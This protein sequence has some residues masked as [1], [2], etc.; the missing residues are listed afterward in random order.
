MCFQAK[1]ILVVIDGIFLF[2]QVQKNV[3]K[4]QLVHSINVIIGLVIE[5]TILYKFHEDY[6]DQIGHLMGQNGITIGPDCNKSSAQHT[7]VFGP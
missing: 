2:T 7:S 3:H 5:N 4:I 6:E 1:I